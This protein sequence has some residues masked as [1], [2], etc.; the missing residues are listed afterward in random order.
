MAAIPI[1]GFASAFGVSR[2]IRSGRER[3]YKKHMG[4]CLGEFGY[5]V[6]DW[7][8]VKKKQPATAM[9]QVP[10][11]NVPAPQSGGTEAL[12]PAK[13]GPDSPVSE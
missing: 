12:K 11:P 9:L 1:V 3:S 2:A 10:A 13:P 5:S 4:Q 8:R 6:V 7:T